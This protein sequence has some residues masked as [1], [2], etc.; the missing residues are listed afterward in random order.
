MSMIFNAYSNGIKPLSIYIIK[1]NSCPYSSDK[2]YSFVYSLTNRWVQVEECPVFVVDYIAGM[3]ENLELL[4]SNFLLINLTRFNICP[5][6]AQF[7]IQIPYD[8]DP[9]HC[10]SFGLT[11]T[12]YILSFGG[13]FDLVKTFD[14]GINPRMIAAN[15]NTEGCA[16]LSRILNTSP[17]NYS[18]SP[19]DLGPCLVYV[20]ADNYFIFSYD[21]IGTVINTNSSAFERMLNKT[22]IHSVLGG[23]TFLDIFFKVCHIS[24]STQTDI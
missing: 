15:E 1:D 6:N 22:G 7:I 10:Q 3:T 17:N 14:Y 23:L 8:L 13:Y 16:Q 12:R 9:V 21:V 24:K 11:K 20:I 18:Q 5:D 2:I 19:K 4:D